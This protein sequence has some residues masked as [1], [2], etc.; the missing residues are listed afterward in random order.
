MHSPQASQ[1][2]WHPIHF[3]KTTALRLC[4][5]QYLVSQEESSPNN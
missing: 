1:N 3:V 5:H 4:I 2:M